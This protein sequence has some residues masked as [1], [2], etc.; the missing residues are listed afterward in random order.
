MTHIILATYL[1]TLKGAKLSKYSYFIHLADQLIFYYL[2]IYAVSVG[3]S[4]Y[5]NCCLYKI[6][7]PTEHALVPDIYLPEVCII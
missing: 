3:R 2:H 4:N 5:V 1:N 7:K 6:V